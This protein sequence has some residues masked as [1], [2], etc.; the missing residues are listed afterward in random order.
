MQTC[1]NSYIQ[2]AIRGSEIYYRYLTDHQ[3][4][5]VE[6]DVEKITHK[7]KYFI[8]TLRSALKNP[9][10]IQVRIENKIY[11]PEEIKPIEYSEKT[12]QL[13]VRPLDTLSLELGDASPNDVTVISDLRFLVKRI[14]HWYRSYGKKI[15][16]PNRCPAIAGPDSH[17][18][19]TQP[20]EEQKDAIHAALSHPFSYIWGAPGTGKTQFVLARCI[21]AYV[22]AKQ[23]IWITAPTNNAVEQMLYGVLP[24]LEEAG[25]PLENVLRMG[26]ASRAFRSR[27]PSVCEDAS[28]AR[29]SATID[30][31]ILK[32]EAALSDIQQQINRLTAYKNFLS[33]EQAQNH[34]EQKMPVR[35]EQIKA[36]HEE[37]RTLES[38]CTQLQGRI[39]L[40]Q[41]EQETLESQKEKHAAAVCNLTRQVEQYRSG[42]R[43]WFFS[44]RREKLMQMLQHEMQQLDNTQEA[45]NHAVES[46][47]SYA[48]QEREL[49]Q[50]QCACSETLL[51]YKNDLC[52]LAAYW[53]PLMQAAEQL[54]E[55]TTDADFLYLHA[56]TQRARD[57]LE[58]R[59]PRYADCS[60]M[61]MDKLLESKSELEQLE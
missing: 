56:Q 11:T 60:E 12:K 9:E 55:R 35:L 44:G 24:V 30:E 53:K 34:W 59:R 45:L 3:R 51:L 6:Y 42:W 4:G 16:L 27:Y 52:E 18:L 21:L 22:Q 54:R 15:S 61:S 41:S 13:T 20:S 50:K 31:E 25:I 28:A 37:L 29:I 19:K 1:L 14:E 17:A 58:E 57:K 2:A 36:S 7:G 33:F 8:L 26:M 38:E 23:R 39:Y 10:M 5:L 46:Q 40:A 47:K 32:I 48:Q 49:Q 43:K